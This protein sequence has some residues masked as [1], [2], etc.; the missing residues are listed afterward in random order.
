TL[1]GSQ[2]FDPDGDPITY[3]WKDQNGTAVGSTAKVQVVIT[4]P[5][6]YSYSLTVCDTHYSSQ[7]PGQT[8]PLHSCGS[9][10]ITVEVVQ[11]TEPPLVDA[12]DLTVSVTDP[13]SASVS[14]SSALSNYVLSGAT[15]SAVDNVDVHPLFQRVATSNGTVTSTTAFP[16]GDTPVVVFY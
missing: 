1:D 3:Q 10:S 14:K 2:S 13:G 12:P 8:N 11:D 5:G 15:T 7:D 4:N 6:N 9:A 16:E